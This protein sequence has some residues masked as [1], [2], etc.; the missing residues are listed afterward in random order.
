MK[1]DQIVTILTLLN[2]PI[3]IDLLSEKSGVEVHLC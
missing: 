2:D 1:V 3:Q